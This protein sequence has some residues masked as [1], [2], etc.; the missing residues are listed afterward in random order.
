[1]LMLA[2]LTAKRQ[3]LTSI[4]ALFSMIVFGQKAVTGKITGPDGQPVAG[5]TVTVKGTNVATTTGLDGRYS[6]TVPG[7][8]TQLVVSYVGYETTEVP[9]GSSGVA[10]LALKVSTTNLNEVVVTGYSA[11]RKKDITGSV[12]VINTKELVANP[13]S[14][15]ESLLQ[16]KAA[17][18]TVGTSGVPG[19][20]ASIRIR[21][22]TTFTKTSHCMLWMVPVQVLSAT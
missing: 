22:F 18:V 5:A 3:I 15:V 10:D 4:L 14:N 7:N 16:G 11:Q 17:G 1:M 21:G 19:A 12:A 9:I 6:I 20:G 13:G 8:R 2:R